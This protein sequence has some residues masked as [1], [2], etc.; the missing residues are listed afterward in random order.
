M[1]FFMALCLFAFLPTSFPSR[2][3]EN[4]GSSAMTDLC[5]FMCLCV[6]A[7]D[8]QSSLFRDLMAEID[9]NHT[10]AEQGH[11]LECPP[12]IEHEIENELVHELEHVPE[13][14]ENKHE[15]EEGIPENVG[16][17]EKNH[18]NEKVDGV[19]DKW[20]G[21]PGEN[22]FRILVPAQKVGSI[23]G[24]KGEYIK[25]TCEETKARIKI[26][27]GPPGMR[28]R[29][30]SA[31]LLIIHKVSSVT[32][33]DGILHPL[34]LE[35]NDI[36]KR[37][38]VLLLKLLV[39]MGLA[40]ACLLSLLLSHMKISSTL[41]GKFT[42]FSLVMVSA[43]E[44]PSAPLPPAINGLL[45]VHARVVDGLENDPS[46]PAPG[47]GGKVSTRLLLPAAQAG[48]LIG[49]Q[50]TTVKSIQ[51]ESNCIVRVLGA[52]SS[53]HCAFTFIEFMDMQT[54]NSQAERMPPPQPWGPPPPQPFPP[55]APTG[56][57]Y[58]ATSFMPPPR[59]FDDYY[60]PPPENQPH[61]GISAYGREAPM[62]PLHTSSSQAA[63]SSLITQITQKMQVPLSYADAVIGTQGAN[64]SYTRRVS[65][66]TITIQE[67]RGVPGE[68]TVEISGTAS[69]AQTAQQLIQNF[70]AE[71]A[72]A[73]GTAQTQPADQM[74]NNSYAAHGSVYTSQPAPNQSLDAYG[75]N[76]GY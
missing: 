29:A 45:R 19:A 2:V 56:G 25:K 46:H 70:M 68:M 3:C 65:G 37:K 10:Q 23:I 5:E 76:Y 55:N 40:F 1:L 8:S 9:Q 17:E 57:G 62:P 28:E 63:A 53:R 7:A 27:D 72:A 13:H 11:E 67:T 31:V 16:L 22:V 60:P 6:W 59:Q 52:G 4:W 42:P 21:W 20:P 48:S 50:G 54:P 15:M 44:E 41:T 36:Y 39:L 35:P 58:G 66:A 26:L 38:S 30:L 49:K 33:R 74:Y 32:S 61:E 51:E 14:E 71:A 24:R 69:Q 12:E 73:A 47:L 18:V 75:S 64:I 43:K 34:N